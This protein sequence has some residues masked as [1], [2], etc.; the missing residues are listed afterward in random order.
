MATPASQLDQLLSTTLDNWRRSLVDQTTKRSTVYKALESKS[1]VTE[2]GGNT[3]RV[4]LLTALNDTVKFYDGYDLFDT[5]PQGGFAHAIYS[6]KQLGGTM[7][8]SGKER[9]I[10][11]GPEAFVSL[12]TEKMKQLEMSFIRKFNEAFFDTAPATKNFASLP[13]LISATNPARGPVGGLDATDQAYW[14]SVVNAGPVDLTTTAGLKAL[15]NMAN[16]LWVNGSVV[17]FEFTT[18]GNFE[19]YMALATEKLQLTNTAMADLGFRAVS[20]GG[21]EIVFDPFVPA[22][23]GSGGGYWYMIN[24]EFIEFVQHSQAWMTR[25]DTQRP[26]NQDAWVTPIICMGNLAIS[27][28]RAHGVIT[29][30]DIT[31]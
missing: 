9:R 18:Q 26:Y 30:V 13:E 1:R 29:N 6:W 17:D 7:T 28:R 8:I 20:H 19:A 2:Q 24:S 31:P 15:D 27:N 22:P 3:I 5:T 21:A 11:N 4:P 16:S 14:Q 23:G 10:N 25:L 12:V